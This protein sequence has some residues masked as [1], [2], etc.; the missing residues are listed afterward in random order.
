MRRPLRLKLRALS[1]LRLQSLVMRLFDLLYEPRD[2]EW[3]ADEFQ[4]AERLFVRAGLDPDLPGEGKPKC[5]RCGEGLAL[6][7]GFCAVC[8]AKK[9]DRDRSRGEG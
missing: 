9:E 8:V 7:G 2:K 3:G 1:R 4:E 6:P 5:L